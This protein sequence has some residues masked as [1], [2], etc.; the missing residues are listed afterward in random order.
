MNLKSLPEEE[1]VSDTECRDETNSGWL[2]GGCR[3]PLFNSSAVYR[4]P[5][6]RRPSHRRPFTSDKKRRLESITR[7]LLHASQT[8]YEAI[9]LTWQALKL[10]SM[11]LGSFLRG[12]ARAHRECSLPEHQPMLAL[13]SVAHRTRSTFCPA[14]LP[15]CVCEARP[16]A[17]QAGL[18]TYFPRVCK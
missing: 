13:H 2:P 6:A 11:K 17:S 12:G 9:S 4:S 10:R 16:G 1:A 5:W 8:P 14:A 15:T 3:P 7:P 18:A